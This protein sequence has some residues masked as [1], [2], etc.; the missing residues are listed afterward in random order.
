MDVVELIEVIKLVVLVV[1]WGVQ[2][3]M[4]FVDGSVWFFVGVDDVG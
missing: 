1:D 2:V 4:E 3:C